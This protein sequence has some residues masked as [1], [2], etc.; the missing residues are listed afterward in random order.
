MVPRNMRRTVLKCLTQNDQRRVDEDKKVLLRQ[1]T[2]E[3]IKEATTAAADG[4]QDQDDGDNDITT[5]DVNNLDEQNIGHAMDHAMTETSANANEEKEEK[6]ATVVVEQHVNAKDALEQDVE[7]DAVH[8][9][10]GEVDF[11]DADDVEDGEKGAKEEGKDKEEHIGNNLLIFARSLIPVDVGMDEKNAKFFII[12]L[13]NATTRARQIDMEMGISFAS[14]LQ[15]EKIVSCLYQSHNANML[16]D[17][18]RNRLRD[19][20]M[21]PQIHRPTK[22]GIKKR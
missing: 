13:G 11:L 6:E 20:H 9:M 21:V 14:L 7:E 4:K 15:D 22:K 3:E 5:I 2:Q 16:M 8:I 19:I 1:K 10:V 18:L 12:I 17:V